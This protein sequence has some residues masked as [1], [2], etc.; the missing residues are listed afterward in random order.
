MAAAAQAAVATAAE[1]AGVAL[2]VADAGAGASVNDIVAEQRRLLE[3]AK[4]L[5]EGADIIKKNVDGGEAD[6]GGSLEGG[7]EVQRRYGTGAA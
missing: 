7:R 4:A 2:Q 3:E 1:N 6:L 5:N